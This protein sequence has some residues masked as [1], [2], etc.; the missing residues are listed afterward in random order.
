VALVIGIVADIVHEYMIYKPAANYHARAIFDRD[1]RRLKRV[2]FVRRDQ[3]DVLLC[4]P[5]LTKT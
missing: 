4:T 1:S 5:P 3:V 2:E